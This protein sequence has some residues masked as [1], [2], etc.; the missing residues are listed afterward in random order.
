MKNCFLILGLISFLKCS[1][2]SLEQNEHNDGI[3]RFSIEWRKTKTRKQ[4]LKPITT[5]TNSPMSQ[6]HTEAISRN[7]RKARENHAR[8]SNQWC[9]TESLVQLLGSNHSA[10]WCQV[11]CAKECCF[12]NMLFLENL[13]LILDLS[14]HII[15]C[16][17]L[18]NVEIS[19][20]R[21]FP[22]CYKIRY[23]I[24]NPTLLFLQA[25]QVQLCYGLSFSPNYGTFTT[26][27]F[28]CL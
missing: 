28:C 4:L 9:V 21:N 18:Q 5:D 3:E 14:F 23:G 10:Y 24:C 25:I 11:F 22:F 13:I 7:R 6:S 17:C 1:V 19:F 15:L 26:T 20:R 16:A 8:R 12:Q 27:W 2:C